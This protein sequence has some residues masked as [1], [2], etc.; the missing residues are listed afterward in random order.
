[1]KMR[2]CPLKR[3]FFRAEPRSLTRPGFFPDR[4]ELAALCGDRTQA[5]VIK[6]AVPR[7][8]RMLLENK[9]DEVFTKYAE[10]TGKDCG[11]MPH[12][13]AGAGKWGPF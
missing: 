12:P 13:A 9:A 3:A 2:L 1:M 7:F 8:G 4:I 5:T 11:S 6:K 10:L